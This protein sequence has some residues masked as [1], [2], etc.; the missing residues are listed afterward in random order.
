M[1]QIKTLADFQ[2]CVRLQELYVRKNNIHDLR[3]VC[4]LKNLPNLHNLW[5]ADN[6]CAEVEGYR[7]AV[8]RALPNL[9]KLDDVVISPE[10]IRGTE[11]MV[12]FLFF[13]HSHLHD[14]QMQPA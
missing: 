14:L 5:L 9:K 1:N 4:Y 6:P 10:E 11:E 7:H 12:P 3:D 2:N 8:L 13:T